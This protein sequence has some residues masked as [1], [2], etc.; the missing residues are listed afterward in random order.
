LGLCLG[1]YGGPPGWVFSCVRGTPVELGDTNCRQIAIER[2]RHIQDSPGQFLDLA[3]RQFLASAFRQVLKTFQV[4]PSS[5]ESGQIVQERY[6]TGFSGKEEYDLINL[7]GR[8][9]E[10][11][12]GVR[13]R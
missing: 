12:E 9:H 2:I 13:K 1:P 5:L 11:G 10:R 4:V 3:F 6:P 8:L 7:V